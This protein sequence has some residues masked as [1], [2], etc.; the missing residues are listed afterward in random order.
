VNAGILSCTSRINQVSNFL[1]SGA[2]ETGSYLFISPTQ[3]DKSIFS[4][5]T[6]IRGNDAS[7]TYASESFAP[8]QAGGCGALYEEVIYLPM[9]CNDAAQKYFPGMKR[10]RELLKNITILVG[11]P[12]VRVF[13]MPAGNGCIVIKKE[14]I[15]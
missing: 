8:N 6:E 2:Q 4:V 7:I 10:E 3:P 15:R 5:S 12:T 11:S 9:S 1:S 14:V 13:L